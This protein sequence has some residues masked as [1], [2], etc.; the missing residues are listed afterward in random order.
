MASH[1]LDCEPV[2]QSAL[3]PLRFDVELP[4]I[5]GRHRCGADFWIAGAANRA[6][7]SGANSAYSDG[8]HRKWWA[9]WLD[10]FGRTAALISSSFGK[11]F[12]R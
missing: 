6:P 9:R 3:H 5:P 1:A 11:L 8:N 10:L 12:A 4:G 2:V 7:D